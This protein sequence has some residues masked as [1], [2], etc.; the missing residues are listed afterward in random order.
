MSIQSSR[1]QRAK[2]LEDKLMEVTLATS[3]VSQAFVEI[4]NELQ[5]EN[6]YF[7][8]KSQILQKQVSSNEIKIEQLKEENFE[9]KTQVDALEEKFKSVSTLLERMGDQRS[10]LLKET[11]MWEDVLT[12][13]WDVE[14]VDENVLE[15][16]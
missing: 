5:G 7:K 1:N 4:S 11:N 8:E 16:Y 15:E 14:S 3:S 2:T 10:A 9:L 13:A 6:A 12:K